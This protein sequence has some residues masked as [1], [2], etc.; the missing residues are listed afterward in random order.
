MREAFKKAHVRFTHFGRLGDD[1]GLMSEALFAAF[2]RCQALMGHPTQEKIDA[3]IPILL[4]RNS[5]RVEQMTVIMI[6]FKR[7]L[8]KGSKVE[9]EICADKLRVFFDSSLLSLH[10]RPYIALVMELGVCG[11]A[12]YTPG[13]RH[14]ERPAEGEKTGVTAFGSLP[15][16]VPQTQT[17]TSPAIAMLREFGER[18]GLRSAN[19][20]LKRHP[21]YNIY[22]YG[23]SNR[24]YKVISAE[25]RV[26]YHLLLANK[27]LFAEYPRRKHLSCVRALLRQKPIWYTT[28]DSYHWLALNDAIMEAMDF[29]MTNETRTYAND[30]V[31][32]GELIEVAEHL[33]RDYFS[34]SGIF[35]HHKGKVDNGERAGGM[36]DRQT[37]DNSAMRG[38][39]PEEYYEKY[40]TEVEPF[41]EDEDKVLGIGLDQEYED[42]EDVFEEEDKWLGRGKTGVEAEQEDKG[43]RRETEYRAV[44]DAHES[45]E[46]LHE[47]EEEIL[48][49]KK[50]K[51]DK[52]RRSHGNQRQGKSSRGESSLA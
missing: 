1:G 14:V 52:K 4:N 43:K 39:E 18:E 28:I 27:D 51:M 35:E 17:P 12:G 37:G 8:M 5:L 46:E 42:E 11:R 30:A 32:S 36:K 25:E 16:S 29:E 31:F 26:L 10:E 50:H 21:R 49:Q 15:N 20:E 9:Y 45:E 41:D 3:L 44:S 6:S 24:I 47:S 13:P 38:E 34:D 40:D 7:R 23:C 48:R 2:L 19:Q 33:H 22:A